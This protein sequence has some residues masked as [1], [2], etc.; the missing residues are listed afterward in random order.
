MKRLN[1]IQYKIGLYKYKKSYPTKMDF[2]FELME[3]NK[4]NNPSLKIS[5]KYDEL[6]DKMFIGDSQLPK[7]YRSKQ[8]NNEC[9]NDYLDELVKEGILKRTKYNLIMNPPYPQ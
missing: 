3:F 1:Q 2:L 6:K 5:Y 8:V 4:S 7:N 9:Y